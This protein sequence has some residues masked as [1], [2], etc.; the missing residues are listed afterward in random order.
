MPIPSG[1]LRQDK[2]VPG[3][4]RLVVRGGPF[5]WVHWLTTYGFLLGFF[6]AVGVELIA[7]SSGVGYAVAG[8]W[9]LGAV[10]LGARICVRVEGNV[11]TVDNGWY[12][13]RFLTSDVKRITLQN[14]PLAGG[15]KGGPLALAIWTQGREGWPALAT[16]S[17]SDSRQEALAR[18]IASALGTR[19]ALHVVNRAGDL[20]AFDGALRGSG[21][22]ISADQAHRGAS[23]IGTQARR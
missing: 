15:G 14:L 12:R 11:V 13:R 3:G 9:T 2:P 19:H 22:R 6:V 21:A 20:R 18:D 1:D 16:V 7:N 17:F 10:I 4:Q 5:F 8:V 23:S